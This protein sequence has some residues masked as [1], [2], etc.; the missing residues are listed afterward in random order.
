LII[1]I[2]ENPFSGI[3]KPEAF[4][5][6]M[7]IYFY[8]FF[9]TLFFNSCSNK[10]TIL[11]NVNDVTAD[12]TSLNLSFLYYDTLKMIFVDTKCGEW[13]GDSKNIKV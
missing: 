4:K 2:N 8:F 3:G 1:A 5:Y 9:F 7:K 12:S 6:N 11:E 10:P 13:G